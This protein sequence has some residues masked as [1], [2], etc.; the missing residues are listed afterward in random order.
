MGPSL[1]RPWNE[2]G[3]MLWRGMEHVAWVYYQALLSIAVLLA[4]VQMAWLHAGGMVAF[5]LVDH[6]IMGQRFCASGRQ[7]TNHPVSTVL[8]KA[9]QSLELTA[10]PYEAGLLPRDHHLVCAEYVLC[11]TS[12]FFKA[13]CCIPVYDYVVRP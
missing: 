6:S 4:C 1:L 2:V 11:C 10:R 8:P 3:D 12:C 7:D 9:M 5:L 13:S